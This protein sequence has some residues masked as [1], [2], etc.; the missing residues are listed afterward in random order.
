MSNTQEI[1]KKKLSFNAQDAIKTFEEALKI[2]GINDFT[3]VEVEGFSE[4]PGNGIYP[5][6]S[7]VKVREGIENLP[8]EYQADVNKLL[9]DNFVPYA[10]IRQGN[11]V[12]YLVVSSDVNFDFEGANG[13]MKGAGKR[14]TSPTKYGFDFKGYAYVRDV[15]DNDGFGLD[16]GEITF[17]VLDDGKSIS[18]TM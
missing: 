1:I 10:V 8:V 7:Q 5:A 15:T 9:K 11:F 6:P 4:M 12:N 18:R 3:Y 16:H 14:Y 13:V 2:V 17:A